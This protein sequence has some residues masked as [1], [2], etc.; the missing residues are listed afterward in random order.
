MKYA[1]MN[2]GFDWSE[3]IE[4]SLGPADR[5]RSLKVKVLDKLREQPIPI[6][7]KLKLSRYLRQNLDSTS[8]VFTQ[9][10]K[11]R[12]IHRHKLDLSLDLWGKSINHISAYH[13]SNVASYFK[14]LRLLVYLNIFLS[15]VVL[16]FVNLPQIL[17]GDDG[18]PEHVVGFFGEL[19]TSVL[20]YGAYSNNTWGTYERPLAYFLTWSLVH[21]LCFVVI[22]TSMFIQYRRSKHDNTDS[23]LFYSWRLLSSWDYNITSRDGVKDRRTALKTGIKEM[24]RDERSHKKRGWCHKLLL[25]VVRLV[26]NV[27]ILALYGGSGYLI[28]LVAYATSVPVEVP[29]FLDD[30]LSKYELPLLVSGLKLVVP[31]IFSILIRA[32][33]WHPRTMIKLTIGRTT[34]FYIASLVVFISSL[35]NVTTACIGETANST[36]SQ[37]NGS[38]FCCWENEVG[39]Q[40][41][42]VLL[43]DL[44]I[45]LL[46]GLAFDVTSAILAKCRMLFKFGYQEFDVPSGVLDL[47]YGQALI[48]L[49]LYFSPFLALIGVLKLIVLFYFRYVIAR[50]C[51]VPPA[52]VFRASRSGNFYMFVLLVNLFVCVFPM[53]YAVVEMQPSQDCGPFRGLLRAYYVITSRVGGVPD[54]LES[55]LLYISTPVIMIPVIILLLLI[56]FYYVAKYGSYKALTK[57]LRNQLRF[58]RRVEKRKVFA[59]ARAVHSDTMHQREA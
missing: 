2:K 54:W 10:V 17:P 13:G 49:G 15:V 44:G 19:S 6:R 22:V 34:L 14:F 20:F 26:V 57:S 52:K 8:L 35:Y 59:R 38:E 24:V 37:I 32:E 18:L 9:G 12:K 47:I 33:R 11:Q 25:F 30:F 21:V 39:E 1:P 48:W 23:D 28:Y 55:T 3:N 36:I 58:E 5:K 16:A 7:E 50:T 56:I 29:E 4:N 27:I 43:I 42:K 31:K 45:S 46:V 40:V 51:N 53:A 41:F